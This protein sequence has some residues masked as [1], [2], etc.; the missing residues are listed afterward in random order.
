MKYAQSR[1]LGL[2]AGSG[3]VEAAG[4]ACTGAPQAAR[5]PLEADRGSLSANAMLTLTVHLGSSVQI[6]HTFCR[7]YAA[8]ASEEVRHKRSVPR[9]R[10]LARR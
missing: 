9:I 5:L 1:G 4:K 2:P 10:L 6:V 3:N 7:W 8:L